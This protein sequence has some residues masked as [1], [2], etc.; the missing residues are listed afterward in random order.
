MRHTLDEAR[1]SFIDPHLFFLTMVTALVGNGIA[2]TDV[3]PLEDHSL[4][5]GVLV[6]NLLIIPIVALLYLQRKIF[7]ATGMLVVASLDLISFALEAWYAPHLPSSRDALAVLLY[8]M[9]GIAIIM[10]FLGMVLR[11]YSS[12]GLIVILALVLLNGLVH[13]DHP[14]MPQMA[15]VIF[16]VI[17]MLCIGLLF[18]RKIMQT[19]FANLEQGKNDL[20]QDH[21]RIEQLK[22][23]S[24]KALQEAQDAEERILFKGKNAA[25]GAWAESSL[26]L[27]GPVL[28]R[29]ETQVQRLLPCSERLSVLVHKARQN[30][31][32]VARGTLDDCYGNFEEHMRL[33]HHCTENAL[34]TIG[35]SSSHG[36]GAGGSRVSVSLAEMAGEALR[37]ASAEHQNENSAVRVGFKMNMNTG[38]NIAVT[39]RN[40][41]VHALTIIYRNALQ[42]IA[43]RAALQEPGYAPWIATT[44]FEDESLCGLCIEDTGAGI[45]DFVQ[46]TL[47]QPFVTTKPPGKGAGLGLYTARNIVEKGYRGSITFASRPNLFTRFI[48]RFPKQTVAGG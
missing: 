16:G 9:Q 28:S 6:A 14:F 39:N 41:L 8:D 22:L 33:L 2:L 46:E 1:N 3:H 24:E 13:I 38:I 5:N 47:F 29:L 43:E 34:M 30:M 10:L 32:P 44:L 45:P 4:I 37:V 19:Q 18:F 40:E 21:D 7:P 31:R 48:I 42:A 26:E 12:L 36:L 17:C 20:M 27:V 15:P 25:I 11:W 23:A 35:K